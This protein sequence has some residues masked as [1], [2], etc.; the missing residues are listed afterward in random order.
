MSARSTTLP[1]R[2]LTYCCFSREP[3]LASRLNFTVAEASVAE[4]SLI[5]MLT[6]PKL[7]VSEAMDRAAMVLAAVKGGRQTGG[8]QHTRCPAGLEAL[9]PVAVALKPQRERALCALR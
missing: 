2:S 3:S 7:N 4:Y 5:G 6:R 8:A 9:R 1:S